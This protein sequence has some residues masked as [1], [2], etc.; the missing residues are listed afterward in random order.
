MYPFMGNSEVS[1]KSVTY[2]LYGNHFA[3]YTKKD[4]K[5]FFATDYT[6]VS[7]QYPE[8]MEVTVDV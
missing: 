8:L 2:M 5:E 6:D 4:I 1:V 7:D 3:P